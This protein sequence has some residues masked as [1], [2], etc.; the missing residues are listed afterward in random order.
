MQLGL[1]DEAEKLYAGCGRY[2]LTLTTTLTLTLTPT[3][4]FTLTLTLILTLTLTRYD[5][6][7]ELYQCSGQW[8]KAVQ[9]AEEKD[10]IHLKATHY[11]HAKHLEAMGQHTDAIVSYEASGTHRTE[12][13][14][15]PTPT[16]TPTPNPNPNPYPYPYPNPNPRPKP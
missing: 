9:V 2:D 16:P 4:T 12:V 11:L 7:N 14:P 13:P 8:D 15:N 6:L 5:L 10:R 3:L 1:I